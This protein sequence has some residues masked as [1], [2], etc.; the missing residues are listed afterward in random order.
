MQLSSLTKAISI[1]PAVC[2]PAIIEQ[3]NSA[4]VTD[5]EVVNMFN[6]AKSPSGNIRDLHVI[7]ENLFTRKLKQLRGDNNT[8]D[9]INIIADMLAIMFFKGQKVYE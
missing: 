6:Q 9:Q 7:A 8:K 2:S 5:N 3:L 4:T 1:Q